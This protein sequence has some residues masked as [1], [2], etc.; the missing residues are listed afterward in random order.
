[1]FV[2]DDSGGHALE[3][4]AWNELLEMFAHFTLTAAAA[5]LG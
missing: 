1:M 5:L 3:H 2:D 4:N